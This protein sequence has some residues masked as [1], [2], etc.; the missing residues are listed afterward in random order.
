MSKRAPR[1]TKKQ[2]RTA[3][4]ISGQQRRQHHPWTLAPAPEAI[5]DAIL[6]LNDRP[7]KWEVDD[8]QRRFGPTK[9]WRRARNKRKAA[10]Q[11]MRG[12]R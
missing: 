1:Q 10:W 8:P 5:K 6:R 12:A 3:A 2:R 9:E 7:E 11:R 4:S